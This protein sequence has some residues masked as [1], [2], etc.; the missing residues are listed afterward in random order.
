MKIDQVE[1]I[2]LIYHYPPERRWRYP[3]GECTARVT[4]LVVVHTDT[5]HVGVGSAYTHPGMVYLTVKH[6]LEP[7]LIGMDPT[8]V[9]T[10][11]QRCYGLTRWYGQKGAVLSAIG[12]LDIAL[13]DLRGK[14]TGQPVWKL[15]G[16]TRDHCPAYASGLLFNEDLSK[17]TDEAQKHVANGFRRMKLRMGRSEEYDAAVVRVVRKA[18]GPG[19]DL[20]ADAGMKYNV[21]LARRIG[22]VLEENRVFWF[23]EPFPPEAIDEFVELRGTIGV[24]VSAGENEFGMHG[25]EQLIRAGAVDIVQPDA[26]RTGGIS[27]AWRIAQRANQAGL[28]VAPHSWSDAIAVMANAHVVAASPNG[29]TVE[30]DQTGTPFIENLLVEPLA[31]R[32]GILTLGDAPG[33]G[34][35]L[36]WPVVQSLRMADPLY[37]PEGVLSDMMFGADYLKP[38]QPYIEKTSSEARP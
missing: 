26:S 19:I 36:N 33:L 34:I 9:E 4:S 27:E 12:A 14:A 2:N 35:E 15:L 31:V 13:W 22:K 11:F 10:I 28:R 30:V 32:E 7:M 1:V 29:I 38:A 3:G 16:G 21:P 20:M 17:L 23:E 25:F 6:Q 37:P 8:D 24:P 5:G 18:I